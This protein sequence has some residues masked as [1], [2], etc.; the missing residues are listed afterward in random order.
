VKLPHAESSPMKIV[1]GEVRTIQA[2]VFDF[3]GLICDTEGA[4]VRAAGSVFADHGAQL[5]LNRWTH[6]IGTAT[7]EHFW[8][9]WLEEQ[10]GLVDRAQVYADYQRRNSLEVA[11]LPLNDGVLTMLDSVAALSLPVAIASSSPKSWV[12]PLASRLGITNRFDTIVC[13]EDAP[14]AKPAPDLYLEALQRLGVDSDRT[15]SA[16]AFEDSRN[17]SL[18]AKAAGMTCVAI[19]GALTK[20][21]DF[22]HVDHVVESMTHVTLNDLSQ[23]HILETPAGQKSHR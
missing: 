1:S 22:S 23:L 9:P 20:A 13:R 4:Q 17:G 16:V 21:Q 7:D 19:P 15:S 8:I 14:Q 6:L 3:D 10:V 5:P 2:I 11:T 18:A 12:V